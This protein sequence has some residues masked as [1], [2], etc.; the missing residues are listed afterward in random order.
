MSTPIKILKGIQDDLPQSKNE[1]CLYFCTDTGNIYLDISSNHR[2]Q[3]SADAAKRLITDDNITIDP[4][5]IALKEEVQSWISEKASVCIR[6]WEA[7]G[8]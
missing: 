4:S 7:S 1:G 5:A 3:V 8:A 6:R 2:I